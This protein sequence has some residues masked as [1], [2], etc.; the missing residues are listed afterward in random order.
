MKKAIFQGVTE[1]GKRL[2]TFK[3]LNWVLK[4][5]LDFVRERKRSKEVSYW[6]KMGSTDSPRGERARLSPPAKDSVS[7]K[8]YEGHWADIESWTVKQNLWTT[9]GSLGSLLHRRNVSSTLAQLSSSSQVA[10]TDC[11]HTLLHEVLLHESVCTAGLT[12]RSYLIIPLLK[13]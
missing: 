9:A 8:E 1:S 2:W 5:S 4:E 12:T 10:T 7:G 3:N 11:S 6:E 13:N